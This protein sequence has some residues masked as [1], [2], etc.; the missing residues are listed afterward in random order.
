MIPKDLSAILTLVGQQQADDV[1]YDPT[2]GITLIVPD[3][4]TLH[5]EP[6]DTVTLKSAAFVWGPAPTGVAGGASLGP[7]G[8]VLPA[9]ARNRP[10]PAPIFDNP[11]WPAGIWG[12][13]QWS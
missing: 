2:E 5:I 4:Q 8:I 9:R 6:F 1:P 12:K 11:T 7:F 13:S 3:S 10:R